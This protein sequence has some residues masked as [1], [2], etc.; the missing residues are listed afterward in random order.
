ME[1]KITTRQLWLE[2]DDCDHP[3]YI[4]GEGRDKLSTVLPQ[5][6]K[7]T[8]TLLGY[9]HTER[10]QGQ[11]NWLRENDDVHTTCSAQ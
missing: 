11:M 6:P 2:T 10:K 5:S 8:Y 3:L 9:Y 4:K 7:F 1:T